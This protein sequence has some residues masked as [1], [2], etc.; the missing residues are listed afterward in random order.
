VGER[1]IPS[2][3]LKQDGKEKTGEM[4]NPNNLVFYTPYRSQKQKDDPNKM[5][6][7]NDIGKDLKKHPIP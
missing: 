4:D 6:E 3:N 2:K 7:D 1:A 5:D